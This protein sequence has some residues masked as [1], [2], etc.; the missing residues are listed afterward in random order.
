MFGL[1]LSLCIGC[2]ISL[3]K[4]EPNWKRRWGPLSTL[5]PTF[6][7]NSNNW[8]PWVSL[9]VVSA[10]YVAV[11]STTSCELSNRCTSV[12]KTRRS[13][14]S[15]QCVNQRRV[16]Y[17][18]LRRLQIPFDALIKELGAAR[19]FLPNNGIES[20]GIGSGYSATCWRSPATCWRSTGTVKFREFMNLVLNYTI[21]YLCNPRL[22]AISR[23]NHAIMIKMNLLYPSEN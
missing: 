6:T 18:I 15:A 3:T 20:R 7:K 17:V 13:R 2:F 16:D 23:L 12:L 10:A 19:V 1:L 21:Y 5:L 9:P 22:A 8:K 11:I 4:K 14:L